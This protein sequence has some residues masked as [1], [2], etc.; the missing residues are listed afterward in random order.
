MPDRQQSAERLPSPA[1]L[2]ARLDDP[3]ERELMTVLSEHSET[4]I[5]VERLLEETAS[6]QGV[7]ID[8][9][10][11]ALSRCDLRFDPSA[12]KSVDPQSPRGRGTA[13]ADLVRPD[14]EAVDAGASHWRVV[15]KRLDA[16]NY[17]RWCPL[18][19]DEVYATKE[20]AEAEAAGRN[21][22][23][24]LAGIRQYAKRMDSYRRAVRKHEALVAAGIDDREPSPPPPPS[25]PEAFN[26]Y[27][28]DEVYVSRLA[29]GVSDEL[30]AYADAADEEYDRILQQAEQN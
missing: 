1:E 11:L 24:R 28:T 13:A 23:L 6:R 17:P 16:D 20:D 21:A 18:D 4:G 14:I 7:T 27:N 26:R 9:A 5:G 8:R 3:V 2:A 12:L 25:G 15:E 10:S 22:A 29:E 19:E 30:R